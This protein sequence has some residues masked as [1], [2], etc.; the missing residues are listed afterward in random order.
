MPARN[1][2]HSTIASSPQSFSRRGMATTFTFRSKAARFSVCV[3]A[4][5]NYPGGTTGCFAR[6]VQR[7]QPSPKTRR[8]GSRIV[9]FE[10]CS[11]FTARYGLHV[12]QVAM[13]PST[14]EASAASSPPQPLRLLL[15]GATVARW[16]SHPLKTGA[17]SRRTEF[18][19]PTSPDDRISGTCPEPV[20][21]RSRRCYFGCREGWPTGSA[22]IKWEISDETG[23]E[24]GGRLDG[25]GAL[26]GFQGDHGRAEAGTGDL[27]RRW[28]SS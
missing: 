15:A 19:D 7:R 5:A 23:A 17:L 18:S 13:R 2:C 24:G 3:R 6:L 4:V 14:P 9:S 16:D 1:P 26:D 8:I 10:A 11:A 12:R 21:M 28:P 20:D 25:V 27:G 22:R